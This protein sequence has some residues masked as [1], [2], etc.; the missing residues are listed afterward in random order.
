[1]PVVVDMNGQPTF[2]VNTVPRMAA[3]GEANS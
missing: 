1:M 3:A 2:A